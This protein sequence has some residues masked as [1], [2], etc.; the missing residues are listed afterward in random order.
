[1]TTKS[2]G[3]GKDRVQRKAYRLFEL[4]LL[5]SSDVDVRNFQYHRLSFRN[6]S[7]GLRHLKLFQAPNLKEPL[8]RHLGRDPVDD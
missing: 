8:D 6:F 7:I 5:A 1:M 2:L 3:L 4:D